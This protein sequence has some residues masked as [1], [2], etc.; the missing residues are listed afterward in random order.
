MEGLYDDCKSDKEIIKKVMEEY[1]KEF[2]RMK[3]S[4]FDYSR[5]ASENNG[6]VG[7]IL[8]FSEKGLF[9]PGGSE[10]YATI[11][12]SREGSPEEIILNMKNLL[13]RRERLSEKGYDGVIL[14][15]EGDEPAEI[16]FILKIRSVEDLERIVSDFSFKE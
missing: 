10:V 7:S 16:E 6:S 3:N 12:A 9:L 14:K 15:N 5:P 11:N 2:F 13:R 1:G 8:E 4:E